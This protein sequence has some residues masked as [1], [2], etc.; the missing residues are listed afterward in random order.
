MAL[1][2]TVISKSLLDS[3]DASGSGVAGALLGVVN[4]EVG[5]DADVIW[6]NGELVSTIPFTELSKVF[7]ASAFGQ[8]HVGKWCQ[9]I[10][11][12]TNIG[13]PKSPAFS[14]VCIGAFRIADYDAP[15]AVSDTFVIIAEPGGKQIV[16]QLDENELDENPVRIA[17][18][19]RAV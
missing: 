9:V 2:D 6:E 11:H 1:G 12:P 10:N 16:V 14:G 8:S 4:A 13:G 7:D 15:A 17:D 5:A 3:G 18:G 19:R